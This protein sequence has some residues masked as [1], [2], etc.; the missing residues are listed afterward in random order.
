[1]LASVD[2][3]SANKHTEKMIFALVLLVGIR[4]KT[5]SFYC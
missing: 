3:R 5:S 1:M 2:R 4:R